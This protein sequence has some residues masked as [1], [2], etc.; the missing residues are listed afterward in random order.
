MK[1]KIG[2]K[3]EIIFHYDGKILKDEENVNNYGIKE[4]DTIINIWTIIII[5]IL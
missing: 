4:N 3:K 5:I 2:L 1:N